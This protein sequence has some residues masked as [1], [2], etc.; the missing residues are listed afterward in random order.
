MDT[1]HF[2][3]ESRRFRMKLAPG[4]LEKSARVQLFP[5]DVPSQLL[6]QPWH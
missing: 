3:D 5:F 2:S 6:E 4:G 1:M